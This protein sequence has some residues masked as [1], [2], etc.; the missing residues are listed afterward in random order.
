MKKVFLILSFICCCMILW[1]GYDYDRPDQYKTGQKISKDGCTDLEDSDHENKKKDPLPFLTLSNSF[2]IRF[3]HTHT[4][5][6]PE[7]NTYWSPH[8][9]PVDD[10]PPE[11]IS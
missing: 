1:Q 4:P 9:F 11:T 3:N 5:I 6:F 2:H 10:N 7:S 8:H